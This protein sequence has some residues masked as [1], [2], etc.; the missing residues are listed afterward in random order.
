MLNFI[1]IFMYF[2]YIF[3]I[4]F[5]FFVYLY[6]LRQKF[7]HENY[8]KIHIVF[9]NK[10]VKDLDKIFNKKIKKKVLKLN[11]F[12]TFLFTMSI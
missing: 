3:K 10:N 1:N 12:N 11:M 2:N 5:R 7:Q 4:F 6:N 9:R 8:R